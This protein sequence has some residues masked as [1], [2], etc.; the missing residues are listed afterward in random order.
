MK[1]TLIIAWIATLALAG[2]IGGMVNAQSA[3]GIWSTVKGHFKN[4]FWTGG[5]G[6]MTQWMRNEIKWMKNEIRMTKE[7]MTA[8]KTAVKNNDYNA[9]VTASGTGHTPWT[10]EF[11]KMVANYNKN[12]AVKTAVTNND[13]N[14]FVTATTP[15]KEEFAKMV[16]RNKEQAAIKTAITNKD[17]NAFVT[18]LNSNTNKPA[19]AKVPT[20]TEFDKIVANSANMPEDDGMWFGMWGDH[21]GKGGP[22]GGFDGGQKPENK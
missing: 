21:K 11:A 19:D 1:K 22:R 9:F 16:E 10:G 2:S 3:K 20:Q 17:Y 8:I 7:Q 15:S 4:H 5:S 14:A 6:G 18:A 12:Q 13:Y